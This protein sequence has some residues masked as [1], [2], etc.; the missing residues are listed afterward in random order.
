MKIIIET[1]PHETQRYPTCGDW[2]YEPDGTLVIKVS[3]LGDW[4]RE[5]LVAVHE[6]VEVLI[7]KHKGIT[8]QQV[9]EF[10]TAYEKDRQ[11][12]LE[13]AQ[14][15]AEKELILI[16]EPGDAPG[17][18]IGREHSVASGVERILAALLE[19]DWG[20]YEKQIETL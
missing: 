18:P 11:Q 15:Q 1:I 13:A 8:V 12:R 19:V 5:A 10:D 3:D 9:D 7:A 6:L 2:Y 16:D 20:P 14:T 4:R 17:C